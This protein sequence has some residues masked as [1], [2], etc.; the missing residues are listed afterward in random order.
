M[1]IGTHGCDCDCAVSAWLACGLPPATGTGTDSRYSK[2]TAVGCA[3]YSV[4]TVHHANNQ[5]HLFNEQHRT[6]HARR[7]RALGSSSGLLGVVLA[8]AL[9]GSREARGSGP[10]RPSPR[11]SPSEQRVTICKLLGEPVLVLY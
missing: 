4:P 2:S 9:W 5:Q 6:Q 10:C 11:V 1:L 7:A 8:R 3:V